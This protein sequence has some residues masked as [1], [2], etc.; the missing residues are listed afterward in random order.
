M[1][2]SH[3]EL[4]D[5]T[6]LLMNRQ[7]EGRADEAGTQAHKE[8]NPMGLLISEKRKFREA[9][10]EGEDGEEAFFFPLPISSNRCPLA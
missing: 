2:E 6:L 1:P 10:E 5:Q 8:K 3:K 7:M 9:K 4:M